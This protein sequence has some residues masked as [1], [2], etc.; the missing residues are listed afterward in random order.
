M[1]IN[2][3][4]NGFDKDFYNFDAVVVPVVEWYDN[5]GKHGVCGFHEKSLNDFCN[6]F[7]EIIQELPIDA[8]KP[9]R[10]KTIKSEKTG[11]YYIFILVHSLDVVPNSITGRKK[12]KICDNKNYVYCCEKVVECINNLDVKNILIH[13]SFNKADF[14]HHMDSDFLAKSLESN[15]NRFSPKNIYI[16]VQDFN[17]IDKKVGV[18]LFRMKRGR[19]TPEEY[20][21]IYVESKIEKSMSYTNR[22]I[23]IAE[24]ETKYNEK[25]IMQQ[26]YEDM[27]NSSWFFDAYINKYEGT[28]SD[29]AEKADISNST[30]SKIKSNTYKAKSKNVIIALAIALDLTINDRKRFI[31]SA[32][33]SYPITEH[34]RFIEQQL[35]KK[36]YTSV[37]DFNRDIMGEHPKFIIE[38]R[39]S[40]GYKNK[41]SDK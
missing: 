19:I 37:I 4:C 12:P 21:K 40:K 33:F 39:S 29:L 27:N 22:L 7:N 28:A 41:K 8:F 24:I 35:R 6:D 3:I 10:V 23:R 16:L 36:Y 25:S 30:I 5:K 13:P 17:L 1:T 18:A 14:N 9:D 32:G 38:T 26:L 20:K 11:I 2:Y 31:N 15:I 34:D